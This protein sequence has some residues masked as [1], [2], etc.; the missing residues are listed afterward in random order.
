MGTCKQTLDQLGLFVIVRY[1]GAVPANRSTQELLALRPQAS[2]CKLHNTSNCNQ[3]P[4]KRW[5]Q[6]ATMG[7]TVI[8]LVHWS[9][10][11]LTVARLALLMPC[12]A[13]DSLILLQVSTA[14]NT[15]VV[16]MQAA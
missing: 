11:C 13:S 16:Y 10:L 9:L 7:C 4:K 14:A 3:S 15:L 6:T 8:W 12:Q 5:F 1:L 2:N